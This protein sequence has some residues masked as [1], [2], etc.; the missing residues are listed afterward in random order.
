MK[1]IVKYLLTIGLA[2]VKGI[3]IWADICQAQQTFEYPF[4]LA[5]AGDTVDEYV[6]K[7]GNKV[8]IPDP[9]RFL[10]QDSEQTKHWIAAEQ[11]ITS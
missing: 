5:I 11:N 9:F 8:L 2:E 10:E 6:G 4:S 1:S 7:D 3:N